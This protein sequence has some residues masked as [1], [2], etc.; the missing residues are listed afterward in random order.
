MCYRS[1][2]LSDSSVQWLWY[3]DFLPIIAATLVPTNHKHS[4]KDTF[5][6]WLC[7]KALSS[8]RR[9]STR[10]TADAGYKKLSEGHVTRLLLWIRCNGHQLVV[11]LFW[12]ILHLNRVPRPRR[13]SFLTSSWLVDC[14]SI[15]KVL[16]GAKISVHPPRFSEYSE[17]WMFQVQMRR[18]CNKW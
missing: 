1:V 8:A 2:N 5:P 18:I 17:K 15:D 11:D 12:D 13:D 7:G 9:R 10:T 3:L 16:W 14:W 6:S 4:W